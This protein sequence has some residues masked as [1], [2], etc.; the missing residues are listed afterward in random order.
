MQFVN[1]TMTFDIITRSSWIR[2]G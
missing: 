1:T 2:H